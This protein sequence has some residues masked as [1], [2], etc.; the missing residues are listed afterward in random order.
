MVTIWNS[1]Q[2]CSKLVKP[3]VP[4]VGYQMA[5]ALVFSSNG[6]PRTQIKPAKGYFE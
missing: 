2:A 4:T 6:D 1:F 3:D 5:S